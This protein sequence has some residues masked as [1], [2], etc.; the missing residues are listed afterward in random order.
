MI[1][2]ENL[3]CKAAEIAKNEPREHV[4][5]QRIEALARGAQVVWHMVAD[6]GDDAVGKACVADA[7]KQVCRDDEDGVPEKEQQQP[8]HGGD[9]AGHDEHLVHA[10]PL[11]RPVCKHQARDF[12]DGAE[13]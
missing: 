1:C 10:E 12:R 2:A 8:A 4:P 5:Y 6:I 9:D 13:E 11:D 7:V 3:A